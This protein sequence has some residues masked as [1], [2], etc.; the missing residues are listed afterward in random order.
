[1]SDR[2]RQAIEA[3]D[4]T[5]LRS[6][7]AEDPS[8][9]NELVEW[10]EC[11]EIRTHPI[12]FICDKL[13]D[14]T[15]PANSGGPLAK[16]L[17]AAG[18]DPDFCNG[19]LLNA[20]TSLGAA[21]VGEVLLDAGARVDLR[22]NFGETPLHWAANIGSSRMVRRLLDHGAP[23]DIRDTKWSATPVGW[24]LH[25]WDD[26]PPPGDNGKHADVVSMLVNAGA[27]VESGWLDS[28][29]ARGREDIVRAFT[30]HR[31]G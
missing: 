31:A 30:M 19:D 1:M 6:L 10:G 11:G 16:L 22:G 2:V 12:H 23:V 24:A 8:R 14:S 15:L 3:G 18:A 26:P 13:F 25:G 27:V 4:V 29:R 7:L 20:A 28:A 17:I 9:A 21:D 5:A